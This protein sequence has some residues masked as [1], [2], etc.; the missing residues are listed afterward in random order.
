MK[1]EV[2]PGLYIREINENDIYSI[3]KYANN[4][5]ISDNL[6]DTF[7]FPY[8]RDDAENWLLVLND[9]IPKS[10]YAIASDEEL[11]GAI[12]IEPSRDVNRYSGELGYWLGE[13]F[14]G[15]GIATIVVKKFIEY[16]F[17]EFDLIKVFAY[18]FSSNPSSAKVLIKAG[19][20]L[21]GC[22]RNQI[23]KKG[24]ILDQLVY[25]ILKEE[26]HDLRFK[27]S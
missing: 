24:R 26:L 18:V 6:R 13:P 1:I 11:I 15:K 19:F 8:T 23:V 5:K 10:S 12:G 4:R 16:V 25:G 22:R 20:K 27:S 14:W 7:P 2:Y 21:E 3:V 17:E 9:S